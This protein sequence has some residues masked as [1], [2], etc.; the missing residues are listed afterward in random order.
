MPSLL[1]LRGDQQE[2]LTT[3]ATLVIPTA[4]VHRALTAARAPR[5]RGVE[6]ARLVVGIR[7]R[8]G[9]SFDRADTAIPQQSTDEADQAQI[10]AGETSVEPV[11]VVPE[12]GQLVSADEQTARVPGRTI[13]E[14]LGFLTSTGDRVP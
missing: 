11:N 6:P 7:G 5:G 2:P 12:H 8:D 9:P 14:N 13:G 1:V 4:E 3:P 10:G